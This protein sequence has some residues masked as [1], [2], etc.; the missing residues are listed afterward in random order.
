MISSYSMS[1]QA[2]LTFWHFG[3]RNSDCTSIFISDGACYVST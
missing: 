1:A 3:F 2:S